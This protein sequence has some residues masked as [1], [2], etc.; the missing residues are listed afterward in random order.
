MDSLYGPLPSSIHVYKTT[1]SLDGSPNVAYYLEADL[2]DKNLEFTTDTTFQRRLTP[3]GFYLKNQRPVLIVNATFFSFA[4]NQNLNIVVSNGKKL[5]SN[6]IR[7]RGK[8]KDSTHYFNPHSSA[9]GIS[10]KR[11]ADIAWIKADS[12]STRILATQ[13]YQNFF[14]LLRE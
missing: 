8:G 1:D 6:I 9:I 4:T 2:N 11:K 10:R 12:V 7:V 13:Q 5:S 3:S 14:L